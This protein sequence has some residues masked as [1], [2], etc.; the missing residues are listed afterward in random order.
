VTMPRTFF[1]DSPGSNC[2][3]QHLCAGAATQSWGVVGVAPKGSGTR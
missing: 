1:V 2:A 3:G